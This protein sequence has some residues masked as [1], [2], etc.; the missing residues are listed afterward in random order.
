MDTFLA[1]ARRVTILVLLVLAGVC[2][3][4]REASATTSSE[5]QASCLQAAAESSVG[6]DGVDGY[7]YTC[8]LWTNAQNGYPGDSGQC[9]KMV[10]THGAAA[11][12]CWRFTGVAQSNPCIANA[13]THTG[14]FGGRYTS[15][16]TICTPGVPAGDGSTVTCK[17]R[18][19]VLSPAVQNQ[20]GQWNTNGSLAPTGDLCD[21]SAG[22]GGGSNWNNSDG[23]PTGDPIP[24]QPDAN[25][26]KPVPPK[27]CGGGSCYDPANDNYC[28]VSGGT[29][30]CIPGNSARGFDSSGN[31]TPT[32]GGGPQGGCA[33]SGDST[34]CAGTPNAPTPP[35]PPKSPIADPPTS[36]VNIDHY[37]QANPATG[38]N[39]PV[40]VTTYTNP[41]GAPVTSGQKPGDSGPAPSS[42]TGNKPGNGYGDGGDCGAPPACTGDAVMCGIARETWRNRCSAKQSAD[43]AHKDLTGDGP[44]TDFD[45]LKGK[46]GQGDVWSDADTSQDGTV[47]GQA[48]NGVYDQSGFG[49]SRACPLHDLAVDM[50]GLGSFSIRLENLCVVG[51]WLRALVIGFALFAAACIT[52]GG[53]G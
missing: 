34:V 37:T 16:M 39:T 25:P 33:S 2:V 44:P 30:V 29:Q 27:T 40:T 8:A 7:P 45:Q 35:A 13:P 11:G 5:A 51:G 10:D 18:F 47:G 22:G 12:G 17:M 43:Q 50:G 32:P 6:F 19:S 26:P 3:P 24:P 9:W 53:R 15:G 46:Y 21:G 4:A 28:G 1:V 14:Q 48:N 38:A 42:S 41:G 52:A 23:T 31:A 49:F 36:I 20:W